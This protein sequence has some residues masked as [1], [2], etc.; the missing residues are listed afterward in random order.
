MVDLGSKILGSVSLGQGPSED[1]T[2]HGKVEDVWSYTLFVSLEPLEPLPVPRFTGP[3]HLTE[4]LNHYSD[5]IK[6]PRDT[7]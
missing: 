1:P 5:L 7:R 4:V 2:N 3:L 6:R